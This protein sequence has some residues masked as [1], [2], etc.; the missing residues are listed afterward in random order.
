MERT[1]AS[2]SARYPSNVWVSD[3]RRVRSDDEGPT[4]KTSV[5][6]LWCIELVSST[7]SLVSR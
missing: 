3:C 5:I 6:L 7:R 2:S 1:S 4:I